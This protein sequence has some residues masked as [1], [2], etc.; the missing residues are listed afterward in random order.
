MFAL[1]LKHSAGRQSHIL[2]FVF[3]PVHFFMR[4]P[5]NRQTAVVLLCREMH[6]RKDCSVQC[7][8]QL[9]KLFLAL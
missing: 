3:V 4:R 7:G 5:F 8:A 2:C 1:K 9:D 6:T